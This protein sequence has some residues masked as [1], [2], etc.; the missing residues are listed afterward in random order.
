MGGRGVSG[1]SIA[2]VDSSGGAP[3]AGIHIDGKVYS[4]KYSMQQWRDLSADE[5]KSVLQ[6]RG[7]WKSKAYGKKPGNG[8]NSGDTK[9]TKKLHKKVKS[10]SRKL[11]SLESKTADIDDPV[12]SS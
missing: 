2:E 1:V 6:A 9:L 11:S 12:E 4:G 5:R 3:T 7:S 10:L 8:A